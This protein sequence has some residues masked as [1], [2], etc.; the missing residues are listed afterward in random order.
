MCVV[1][2]FLEHKKSL[3]YPADMRSEKV[4]ISQPRTGLIL[5]IFPSMLQ[6]KHFQTSTSK[7]ASARLADN[8]FSFTT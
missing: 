6:I 7:D 3:N 4:W 5:G 1:R 8:M 2:F